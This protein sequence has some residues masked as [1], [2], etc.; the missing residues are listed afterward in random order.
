MPNVVE[1]FAVLRAVLSTLTNRRPVR[2]IV[3]L[4]DGEQVRLPVPEVAATA[5]QPAR[6]QA[7]VPNDVQAGILEA[8]DGKAMRTD[9]L[10]NKV[11]CDRRQLFRRPGG[12]QELRDAGLVN[13]HDRHGYFR[14]DCPPEGME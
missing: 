1:L 4:D 12:V 6:G 10:A 14:P 3:V 5:P 9:Q 8:L 13:H 7:F 2:I 11:G